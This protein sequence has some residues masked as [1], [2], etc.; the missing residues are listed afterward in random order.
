MAPTYF[1]FLGLVNVAKYVG[2]VPKGSVSF[3]A[4]QFAELTNCEFVRA[5]HHFV[6]ENNFGMQDGH[7]VMRDYGGYKLGPILEK[8]GDKIHHEFKFPN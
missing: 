3:Q 8:Y 1:S 4:D 5:G 7:L 2:P 6:D